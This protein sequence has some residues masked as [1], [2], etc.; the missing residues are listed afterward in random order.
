MENQF[1]EFRKLSRT[2][3]KNVTGGMNYWCR[4]QR[5]NTI[6]VPKF[7][8]VNANGCYVYAG[9]PFNASPAC[10]PGSFCYDNPGFKG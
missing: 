2:E 10:P 1:N 7:L 6:P 4:R 9:M 3:L 8:F 5:M